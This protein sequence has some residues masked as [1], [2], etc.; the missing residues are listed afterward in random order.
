MDDASIGKMKTNLSGKLN[1][2]VELAGEGAV[3]VRITK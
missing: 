2:S 1:L 3:N